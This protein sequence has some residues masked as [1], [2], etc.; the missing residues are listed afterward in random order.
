M[1]VKVQRGVAIIPS[2]KLEVVVELKNSVK[3]E[4][5]IALFGGPIYGYYSHSAYWQ[6]LEFVKE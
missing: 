1:D 4:K 6:V 5:S 2:D 3:P